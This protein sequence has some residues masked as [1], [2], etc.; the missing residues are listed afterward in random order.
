MSS[1]QRMVPFKDATL[2]KLAHE[3]ADHFIQR[4]KAAQK[5]YEKFLSDDDDHVISD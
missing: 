2:Q 4:N 5:A 3:I 1:E